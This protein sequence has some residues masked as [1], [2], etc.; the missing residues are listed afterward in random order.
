M[1]QHPLS[2]LRCGGEGFGLQKS[3]LGDA[4]GR[5]DSGPQVDLRGIKVE[6]VERRTWERQNAASIADLMW[7]TEAL[8]S[9]IKEKEKAPAG[10]PGGGGMGGMY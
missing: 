7:T 9:E 6:N 5:S 2:T 10:M 1:M 3:P 8:V 4:R